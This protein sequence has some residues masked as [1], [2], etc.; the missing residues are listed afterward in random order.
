M[1]G[2]AGP[3]ALPGILRTLPARLLKWDRRTDCGPLPARLSPSP[4]RA[5]CAPPPSPRA[6]GPGGPG[7]GGPPSAGRGLRLRRRYL[8]HHPWCP[9]RADGD[10]VAGPTTTSHAFTS[11]RHHPRPPMRPGMVQH[12]G[13]ASAV[14]G[15]PTPSTRSLSLAGVGQCPLAIGHGPSAGLP[16]ACRIAGPYRY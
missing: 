1:H 11:L 14:C 10:G 15:G 16:S 8:H 13:Q 2:C 6:R 4:P 12:G 9:A 7:P 3:P 5:C